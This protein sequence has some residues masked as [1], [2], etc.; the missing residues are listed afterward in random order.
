MNKDTLTR[1]EAHDLITECACNVEPLRDLYQHWI[2]HRAEGLKTA[3][4]I[5]SVLREYVDEAAFNGDD[6]RSNGP[7]D[8]DATDLVAP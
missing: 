3:D 1:G 4:D 8:S 2:G 7:K 5:E 6:E